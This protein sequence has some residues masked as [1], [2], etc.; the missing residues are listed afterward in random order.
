[1]VNKPRQLRPDAK[2][3][4]HR[5]SEEKSSFRMV[6]VMRQDVRLH[7]H[8]SRLKSSAEEENGYKTRWTIKHCAGADSP[9]AAAKLAIFQQWLLHLLRVNRRVE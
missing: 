2:D 6:A 8:S 9:Q 7:Q 1:M 5:M 3:Q 4:K